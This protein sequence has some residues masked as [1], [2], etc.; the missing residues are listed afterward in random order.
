MRHGTSKWN[1]QG[2]TQGHSN[3]GLSKSGKDLIKKTAIANKNIKFDIIFCSPLKRAV[4]SS[5]LINK[6]HKVKI[7]KDRRLIEINQGIFT[8]RIYNELTP[9]ELVQKESRKSEFG[10]E[11]YENAYNR[12]KNFINDLKQ[13]DYNN[14]LIVTHHFVAICIQYILQNNGD[15]SNFKYEGEFNNGEVKLFEITK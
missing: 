2:K 12:I 9:L 6:Y 15:Y 11:S 3:N 8:G 13:K 5:K 10:M 14:V 4:Q 1:E 7:V